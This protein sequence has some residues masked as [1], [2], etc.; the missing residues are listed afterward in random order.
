MPINQGGT[1][2][3]SNCPGCS[4]AHRGDTRVGIGP[5]AV[6]TASALLLRAW[7]GCLERGGA[8]PAPRA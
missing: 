4:P 3:L 1:A 6:Q 7:L 2:R 8:G 5:V